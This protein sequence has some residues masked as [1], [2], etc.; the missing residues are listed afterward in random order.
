MDIEAGLDIGWRS[1]IDGALGTPSGREGRP[2]LLAAA[3]VASSCARMLPMLSN[4][5]SGYDE[6]EVGGR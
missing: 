3:M 6:G 4:A 5:S 2:A 1:D